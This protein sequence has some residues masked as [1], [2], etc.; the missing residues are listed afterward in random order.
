MLAPRDTALTTQWR[1]L[2]AL[3]DIAAEWRALAQRAAE[4]NAF[5]EPAFAL[6]AARG[7]DAPLWS[8]RHA[9]GRSRCRRCG[10][11]RLPR[12][13]RRR[14]AAAET[15]ADVLSGRRRPGVGRIRARHRATRGARRALRRTPPRAARAAGTRRLS[16]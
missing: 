4:P 5:Y 13:H 16:R 1:P 2:A 8:A 7:L 6:A 10:R 9:A 11:R 15:A 12:P 14:C 3:G